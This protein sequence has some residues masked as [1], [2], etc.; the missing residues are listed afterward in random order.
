MN[1]RIALVTGAGRGIGRACAES[2]AAAGFR[3]AI[4]ARDVG[5]LQT[6]SA[7][8]VTRGSIALV[9]PMDLMDG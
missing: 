1:G 2:L 4:T 6:V 5:E 8:I 7:E 9:I 3:V